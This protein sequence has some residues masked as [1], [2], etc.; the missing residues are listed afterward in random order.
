MKLSFLLQ[1]L[2]VLL[3]RSIMPKFNHGL[4]L[5]T[6]FLIVYILQSFKADTVLDTSF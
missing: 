5:T 1:Y 4:A 2:H 6:Y 3:R